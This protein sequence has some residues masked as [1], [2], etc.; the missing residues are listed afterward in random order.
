MIQFS[1]STLASCLQELLLQDSENPN[2]NG[3]FIT[4]YDR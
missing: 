1:P 4:I 2:Y 3:A